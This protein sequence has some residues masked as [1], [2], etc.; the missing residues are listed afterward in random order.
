MEIDVLVGEFCYQWKVG[1]MCVIYYL[2]CGV[3]DCYCVY[4]CWLVMVD[5]IYCSGVVV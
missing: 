2:Y 5:F 3:I 1:K 4:L